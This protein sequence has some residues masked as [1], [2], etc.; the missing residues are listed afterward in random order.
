MNRT[1][2]LLR[3]D[4]RKMTSFLCEGI[5]RGHLPVIQKEDPHREPNWLAT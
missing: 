5:A 1:S 2:A 3:R 4:K